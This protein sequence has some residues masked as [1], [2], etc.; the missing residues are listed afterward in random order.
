MIGFTN[1]RTEKRKETELYSLTHRSRPLSIQVRSVIIP[2]SYLL[3]II[4]IICLEDIST[5]FKIS[6][7]IRSF[8]S[9]FYKI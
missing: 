2:D 5:E 8:L 6:N 3:Y 1:K 9:L 4:T 7:R